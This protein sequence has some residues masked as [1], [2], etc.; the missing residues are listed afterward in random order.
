MPTITLKQIAGPLHQ[1][2]KERAMRHHRSL[3]QEILSCL[4]AS[5]RSAAVD[6]E[7]LIARARVLR[8]QISGRLTDRTLRG[9]KDQGRA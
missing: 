3:N 8:R 5:V 1:Q 4:E 9:L 6:V 2:L 7:T